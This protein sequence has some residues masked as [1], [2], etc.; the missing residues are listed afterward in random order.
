MLGYVKE[1]ERVH[2][3][4]V[5]CKSSARWVLIHLSDGRVVQVFVSRFLRTRSS[6]REKLLARWPR[7]WRVGRWT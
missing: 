5:I 6:S 7:F 1:G 2:A 4:T 3:C